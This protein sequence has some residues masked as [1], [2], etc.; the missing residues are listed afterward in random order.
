MLA[1]RYGS[2]KNRSSA[3]ELRFSATAEEAER[4]VRTIL[5]HGEDIARAVATRHGLQLVTATIDE[6]R[7]ATFDDGV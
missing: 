6:M 4:D 7:H 3:H 2:C 5:Q 1:R